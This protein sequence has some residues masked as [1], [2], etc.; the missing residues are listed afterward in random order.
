ML[1]MSPVGRR[2]VLGAHIAGSIPAVST[3]LFL[4]NE[5]PVNCKVVQFLL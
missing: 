1:T 3:I 2:A 5:I 4:L